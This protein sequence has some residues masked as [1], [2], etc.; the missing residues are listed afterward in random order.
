MEKTSLRRL[1]DDGLL[2]EINRQILHPLGLAFAL[3]WEDENIDGEPKEAML[4]ADSDPEGT[5]FA[6]ETFKDGVAKFKAFMEREGAARLE[7]R[8][9][10]VGFVVQDKEL[11]QSG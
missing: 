2:F 11:P 9:K 1:Y 6:D 4:L 3:S 8:Q 10:A 5:V 7:V